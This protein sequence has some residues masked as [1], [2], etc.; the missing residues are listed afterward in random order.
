[1][2]RKHVPSVMQTGQR[3]GMMT[4]EKSI[5]DLIGSGVISSAEKNS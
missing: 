4:M 5:E 1:M 2:N 3:E